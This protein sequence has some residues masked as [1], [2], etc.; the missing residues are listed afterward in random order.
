MEMRKQKRL[1][2]IVPAINVIAEDDFITL[3]PADAGVHFA[4]ADV[5]QTRSLTEQ[6]Q[7]MIDDAPRLGTTLAKAGVGVITF[8]CTSASFFKGEGSDAV[9][10][11]AIAESA[12]VPAIT[13]ATAVT[14]ALK[15]LKAGRIGIATP[16]I[17]WVFEAER[18]FFAKAGFDVAGITGMNRR[19]GAEVNT[20]SD[21][22]IRAIVDEVDGEGI[23][24]LFVSCTDLPALGL[25]EE[26]E[27]RHQK[28]VV[29]S[30]QATFW[31]A[32]RAL[33]IGPIEGYGRLLA[34]H[35]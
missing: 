7:Q 2:C 16:Y 35:L 19:G 30:N 18:A 9:I 3:C 1:G 23:D 14:D 29:S 13:T 27:D 33:G 5:D 4:R 32:A 10:A 15:T 34:R 31:T 6:F 25:I 11:E 28:P 24:T 21:D 22:E 20:I 17:E 12:G 8:A 26:L